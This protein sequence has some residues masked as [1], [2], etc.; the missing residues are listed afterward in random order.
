MSGLPRM[1]SSLLAA[2]GAYLVPGTMPKAISLPRFAYPPATGGKTLHCN[3]GGNRTG[4]AALKRTA[5]AR[6]NIR[7]RSSKR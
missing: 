6:K 1:S 2:I 4:A 7:A 5:K 3:N